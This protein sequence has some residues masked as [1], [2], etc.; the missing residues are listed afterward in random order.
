[1]F[2][3]LIDGLLI[4]YF[5]LHALLAVVIDGQMIA[6]PALY[7]YYEAFGMTKVVQDWVNQEGDCAAA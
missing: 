7:Q 3:R 5:A 1:M 6:P 4:A 2:V